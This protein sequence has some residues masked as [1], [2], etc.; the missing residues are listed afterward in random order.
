[1]P[2]NRL[3]EWLERLYDVEVASRVEDFL[4]EDRQTALALVAAKNFDE[5]P[6][7]L[8]VHE[9]DD[10]MAVSL[11][12]DASVMDRL[13]RKD[14]L[15]DLD[16]ANLAPLMLAVEGVSHFLCLVW[17]AVAERPVSQLALELQAEV[18][19]FVIGRALITCQHGLRAAAPLHSWL[20][21]RSRL[22]PTLPAES[23]Q[24]YITAGRL[25]ADYCRRLN[26]AAALA[27]LPPT[28]ELRRFFRLSPPQK[29]RRAAGIVRLS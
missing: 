19:K 21:E 9:S 26:R 25:A 17:H 12:L 3:Q 18:D 22:R 1:M 28:G 20:F 23:R 11:Y 29:L 13:R 4:I 6:E 10:E 5:T 2:L 27:P 14:P 16:A 7:A 24:R 8:L 15:H